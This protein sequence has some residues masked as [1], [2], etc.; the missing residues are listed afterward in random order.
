MTNKL[1]DINRRYEDIIH[2]N[3]SQEEKNDKLRTLMNM[4]EQVYKIPA[5]RNPEWEQENK[6][7]IALYRKIA[8]S[9]NI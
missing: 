8:M 4:M 9:R 7:V 1:S 2:S 6:A 5:Q 3:L